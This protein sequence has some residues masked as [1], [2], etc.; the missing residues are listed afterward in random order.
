MSEKI[1]CITYD[2]WHLTE[3]PHDDD[4]YGGYM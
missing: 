2:Y 4:Y 1:K 3:D